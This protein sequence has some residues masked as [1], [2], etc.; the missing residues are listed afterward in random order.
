[1]DFSFSQAARELEQ[2]FDSAAPSIPTIFFA[3]AWQA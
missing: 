3:E 1:M 2:R